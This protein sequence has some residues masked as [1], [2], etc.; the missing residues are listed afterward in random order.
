MDDLWLE[1]AAIPN[2]GPRTVPIRP[3][4]VPG[5]RGQRSV[6]PSADA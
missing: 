5:T 4:I 1:G 2:L 3:C 6:N